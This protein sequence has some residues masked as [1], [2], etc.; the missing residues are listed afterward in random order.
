MLL[1][2]QTVRFNQTWSVGLV[3]I[4]ALLCIISVSQIGT[5]NN[6]LF[7]VGKGTLF[8]E[9][10]N[11]NFTI[12]QMRSLPDI[13][14]DKESTDLLSYGM[15]KNP[16]WFK[17]VIPTDT[18]PQQRLL[19]VD[20][21]MLD[22]VD[23]WY[24]QNDELVAEYHG[25]D[26]VP[27]DARNIKNEKLLFP[28]P[29]T[30]NQLVVIVK[31]QT[32]GT[33]K[34]PIRIW[35]E[36]EYLIYNGEHNLVLGLF[37]GFMAAMTLSN[38]FFYVTTGS[39]TFLTYS[40][41]VVSMALTLLTMHGLGFKYV[42]PDWVWLQS[43]SVGIF[44]TS[45]ILFVMIFSQQL[46][47]VKAHSRIMD[48]LLDI[49]KVVLGAALGASFIIPYHYYIMIF[50]VLLC[51][52]VSLVFATGMLLWIKGVK[53]ARFYLLAWSALLVSGFLA[54]F[55]SADII[56]MDIAA[57][58]LLMLGAAIE[59]FMLAFA[60]AI[61]YGQ[62]RDEQYKV[63]KLALIEEQ[64]ARESQDEVLRLKEEAQEELEYKVQERTLELEIALRELSDTNNEL[65]QQTLTDSLTGIRNRKHFDRKYQAEVRRCRREQTELSIVMLDIDN[66]KQIN[67][68][69]GHVLGDEVI[70][71]VAKV[72][73]DNLKRTTDDA[74]RYGG[75]EFALILPSTDLPGATLVAETVREEIEKNP[76]QV[77]GIEI[78]IT[79]SAGVTTTVVSSVEDEKNLLETADRFLYE[80]KRGG[81]NKVVADHLHARDSV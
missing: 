76:I 11:D 71:S 56:K 34:L 79:I 62:Q 7:E 59:T 74:C 5:A 32:A 69:H 33:V 39:A 21:A 20:Y 51:L 17:F 28:V 53:L 66:F 81:R 10:E 50:L 4:L 22:K 55:E 44:A 31:I 9:D 40:I 43:R 80:A 38:L 15:N 60:L 77:D 72:L 29:Q 13:E 58:Y 73:K 27:F 23:I 8:L 78:N 3:C 65:E 12:E 68:T 61:A 64:M 54:S 47:N 46:L 63:Q 30:L 37:F 24:F 48:K 49:S 45:T 41:Y 36:S 75:E 14:W 6:Y 42:W 57:H 52:S 18:N 19:E 25:G 35:Q 26:A 67:D 70:I 16:F 2:N 1:N